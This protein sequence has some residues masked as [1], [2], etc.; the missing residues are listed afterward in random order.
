MIKNFIKAAVRNLWKTKGYSFLN[1]FGLAVGIAAASLIFLWVE[2]ELNYNNYFANKKDLY[3]VK[4]KQTYEG[5]NYVFEATQGPLGP[6]IKAEVPGIKYAIRM[7]WGANLL[8]NVGDKTIYQSGYHADPAVIDALSIEIIAGSPVTALSDVN[9]IMLSES[10]AKRLFGAESAVGKTVK[11]NSDESYTVSAVAKDFPANSNFIFDWIIPFKRY[12]Q[13]KEW[14]KS[15]GSNSLMTLVQLEPNANLS[16]INEQLL[17]F[18]EKKTDGQTTFS[19]NF[20]YP[21]ERWRMYNVFDGD[22]NEQEGRIKNVRLFSIIA[23]VVLLIACI[24]FMNLATARSEKR[25][26][27]IGMRKVVGASRR[28]LVWQFLSESLLFATLSTVLAVLLAKLCLTPFNTLVSKELTLDLFAPLHLAYLVS[29]I[30]VCGVLSGSYPALYL[31]S[32]NPL[33]TLKGGKQNAGAAGFIRR[34]LVVLQYTASIVLI[35]CTLIIYQ[36]IQHVKNRDLGFDRSQVISTNLRGDMHKKIDVIKSELIATGAVEQAGISD[37]N[38]M[39]IYSN[40][41]DFDWEGKD[42]NSSILIG[43]LAT[44]ADFIPALGMHMYDGRNFNPRFLSD[45]TSVIVNEA[46]AKLIKPDGMVAGSI[47]QVHGESYNIAGVVKNFVYNDIYSSPE[48]VIFYP[49]T[50][51]EGLLNIKTK[52][53]IDV[54]ESIKKIEQVIKT[55]NPGYPF[56][57]RF[58][59]E[60]F[61]GKFSGE[62]LIQKLA[63]VFA[64]ISII[65]SCL[66]LL[67]L[68][69]YAAEQRRKEIGI[70]KVLGASV[71]SLVGMLNMEFVKLVAISCLVAFPIAWWIM[72]GWLDNYAYH[73]N[74]SWTVF[75]SSGILALLIALITISTQAFRAAHANPTTTL[76]DQ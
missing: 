25:A 14:L 68:A 13:G 7:D 40:S 42:E 17:T 47:L 35:I 28:S 20:L 65:I 60:T 11:V 8:F 66:G 1:I 38:I 2:D 67:G 33:L 41:S 55:Y 72:Y 74:I 6:A 34:S 50:K 10:G 62:M 56:S 31:S 30:L 43:M 73:I 59:D 54:A 15:Y 21:M 37:M 58:L 48:P 16:Q 32:F 69:S 12:E 64:I 46:L 36:Q 23:W 75:I 9:S 57:Y 71:R 52:A 51:N 63:A 53:G 44:D 19:K 70:R 24:N 4:S 45:S 39:E 5:V 76:R 29:I 61:Q 26:K 22:A 27:E 3:I 49:F 18:V